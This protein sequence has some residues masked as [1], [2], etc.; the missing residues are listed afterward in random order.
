MAEDLDNFTDEPKQR[1]TEEQLAALTK[2]F[3]SGRSRWEERQDIW[4]KMRN[5]GLRRT[6]MPFPKAADL[7]YPLIDTAIEK[8]TPFYLQQFSGAAMLADFIA[9]DGSGRNTA[10]LSEQA[11][12]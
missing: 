12:R 9:T 6:R 1:T 4:Y 11:A 2:D 8:I 5:H 10:S 7:H 3:L